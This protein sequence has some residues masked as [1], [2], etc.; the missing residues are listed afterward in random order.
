MT[1][2]TTPNNADL[3][4]DGLNFQKNEILPK[5]KSANGTPSTIIENVIKGWE[6]EKKEEE[7]TLFVNGMVTVGAV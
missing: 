2:K 7:E 6:K 1:R 4:L 3:F 5:L